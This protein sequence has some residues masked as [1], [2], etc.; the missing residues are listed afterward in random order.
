MVVLTLDPRLA[1]QPRIVEGIVNK[2][3]EQQID[4][5]DVFPIVNTEA[6]SFVYF[7]D[8]TNAGAD[9]TAGTMGVP[10]DLTELA[11]LTTVDVSPISMKMGTLNR[12]GY[13]LKISQRD[14]RTAPFI[15]ELTR[16][17]DRVSFGIAKKINDDIVLSL[18]GVVND[19]T[20]VSGTKVWTDSDADPVTDIMTFA[21]TMDIEGFP[22]ELNKLYLHK[23]QYYAF[24]KY[25]QQIDRNWAIDP[26]GGATR[27]LPPVNG[28]QIV[29]T[30]STQLTDGSY[31]GF[32]TRYPA[33][34]VYKFTD[35]AFSSNPQDSRINVNRY[36][37]EKY[38]H[39]IV[40]EIFA[41]MGIALKVPNAI[42]Y[43]SSGI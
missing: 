22:Y 34:T 41:E 25:M 11:E 40:I 18:Q 20:E 8:V 4:F 17:Y 26:T 3:L 33:G 7:E 5:L 39:N 21:Q 35:P 13:E 19:I 31:L 28:V 1:I 29:N 24:L 30:H 10:L 12:F 37:E 15:D 32:D 2:K 23:T 14:L 6:T 42:T 36:T 16:A 9:M 38:P 43:K 27:T